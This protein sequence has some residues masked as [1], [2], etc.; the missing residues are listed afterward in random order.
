MKAEV[1]IQKK[2]FNSV[3]LQRDNFQ[4]IAAQH[5]ERILMSNLNFYYKQEKMIIYKYE[6][7]LREC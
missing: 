1:K 4:Q 5:L 6:K 2:S 3:I 7:K